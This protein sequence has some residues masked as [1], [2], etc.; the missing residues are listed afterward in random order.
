MSN[1]AYTDMFQSVANEFAKCE[2]HL[3]AAKET[4]EKSDLIKKTSKRLLLARLEVIFTEANGIIQK[5]GQ[6]GKVK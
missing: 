6:L 5:L 4:I 2:P 3:L 1:E